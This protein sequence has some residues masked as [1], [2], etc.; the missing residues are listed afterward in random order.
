MINQL[1]IF[2]PLFLKKMNFS[3][4][5]TPMPEGYFVSFITKA[6]SVFKYAILFCMLLFQIHCWLRFYKGIKT[7]SDTE[8]STICVQWEQSI[9]IGCRKFVQLL[10]SL[11][12][13]YVL[14]E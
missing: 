13:L 3:S 8:F 9:F 2:Q 4:T 12:I 6:P 10:S 7:L 11:T 14:N 5:C 1:E